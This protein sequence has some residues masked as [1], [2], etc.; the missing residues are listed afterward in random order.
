MSRERTPYWAGAKSAVR[1]YPA[2][3]A[4][5]E[6]MRKQTLVASMSG[7]PGSGGASRATET[8]ALRELPSAKQQDY[9]AVRC[10]ISITE[11]KPA[12]K[13]RMKLIRLMYWGAELSIVGAAQRIPCSEATAKRWHGEF[14]HLV[15]KC[16]GLED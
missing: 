13:E 3:K 12:G 15:L 11:L 10:A 2:L 16:R 8:V 14:I 4:E 1:R 7:M 5:L 9:D 6:G